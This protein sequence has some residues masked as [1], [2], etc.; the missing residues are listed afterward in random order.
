MESVVQYG[1]PPKI[2][3]I[4]W[5]GSFQPFEKVLI[6]GIEMVR[7]LKFFFNEGIL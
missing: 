4:K 6:A 7:V 5:I 1:D 3:V 2:G